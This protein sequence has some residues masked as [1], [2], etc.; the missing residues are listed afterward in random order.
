MEEEILY[1][2]I[3]IHFHF[4]HGLSKRKKKNLLSISP[5][6][7]HWYEASSCQ[8]A[9]VKLR[10]CQPAGPCPAPVSSDQDKKQGRF[11]QKSGAVH[12]AERQ[13]DSHWYSPRYSLCS[14][15]LRLIPYLKEYST[16]SHQIRSTAS[17]ACVCDYHKQ[18]FQHVFL[19]WGKNE[20]PGYF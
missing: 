14:L 11:G 16:F 1:I 10:P 3:V 2:S 8:L 12:W 19:S 18:R 9:T 5:S 15:C 6:L 17:V 13:R 20:K 7:P 4:T